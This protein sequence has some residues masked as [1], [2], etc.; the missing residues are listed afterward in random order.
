MVFCFAL[1]APALAGDEADRL[2]QE[3][4]QAVAST[5][6]MS[7]KAHKLRLELTEIYDFDGRVKKG[8]PHHKKIIEFAL[9]K[10]SADHPKVADRR[11]RY[12][13]ALRM[14]GYM[15]EAEEQLEQSYQNCLQQLG[16][17][18]KKTLQVKKELGLT[19]IRTGK[20]D[21]GIR[22]LEEVLEARKRDLGESAVTAAAM[23]QLAQGYLTYGRYADAEALVV[24]AQDIL[25]HTAKKA[26]LPY[27]YNLFLRG[28]IELSTHRYK[29][30][31]RSLQEGYALAAQILDPAHPRMSGFLVQIGRSLTY[32]GR[33]SEAEKLLLQALENR[34]RDLGEQSMRTIVIMGHLAR[35]Y[36]ETGRDKEAEALLT[37]ANVHVEG[38]GLTGSSFIKALNRLLLAELYVD[39]GRYHEAA[40]HLEIILAA[41][42]DRD[43]QIRARAEWY[44]GKVHM[45]ARQYDQALQ[46][47]RKA[48][49]VFTRFSGEDNAL[50]ARALADL[51]R[52]Y[53]QQ[54]DLGNAVDAYRRAMASMVAFLKS[55][56]AASP[57]AQRQQEEYATA[58]L[59]DYLDLM[60]KLQQG[61]RPADVDPLAEGFTV[62]ENARSRSLQ[63]AL[64]KMSARA[65]TRDKALAELVRQEQNLRL[66]QGV[67][68]EQLLEAMGEPPSQD[69]RRLIETLADTRKGLDADLEDLNR[70]ILEK[71]PGYGRLINPAT[72]G[73]QDARA[74]LKPGEV[75]LSYFVQKERTL[76]WAIDSAGARLHILSMGEAELV[77]KIRRL[78]L[79]MDVTITDL[80]R[81]P[82]Y[83]VALAHHLYEKLLA[84]A[85]PKEARHLIVVPHGA[86]TNLPFGALVTRKIAA[87]QRAPGALPFSE[88]REVPWLARD[89]AISIMPSATA[90]VTMRRFI[91]GGRAELAFV[92]FGDPQFGGGTRGTRRGD[93]QVTEVSQLPQLPETAE[94]LQRIQRTFGNGANTRLF[95]GAAATEENV[96][97]TDLSK[98]RVVTFATHGLLAGELRGLAQ[99]A[100]ALTP[101][102]VVSE[103]NNGLL[104]MEEVLE[105]NM[106]ADWVVLS[107]CNTAGSDGSLHGENLSGLAT[108]FF[109][110]GS[111]AMLV[112]LWP[113]VSSATA[114]LMA[115]VF[116][117]KEQSPELTRAAALAAARRHLIKGPGLVRDGKVVLSYAHPVFWSA[118][119][120]VGEGG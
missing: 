76:L 92:G 7:R 5:G 104:E 78:R 42:G 93:G 82:A 28:T 25:E 112:S 117:V 36:R 58:T 3:L 8:L 11:F 99:P 14:A 49:E 29:A 71:F 63:K 80:A 79:S 74:V 13:K 89:H 72:S 90:L 48:V 44:Q 52:A 50:T 19:Y 98:Y 113:V 21:E 57:A 110:A 33:Y 23:M 70:N 59:L 73:I 34:K 88:Y 105:L 68:E 103:E 12:G 120:L 114:E 54:G 116:A 62:A 2:E 97:H 20:L 43:V 106:N 111:R 30:A 15:G 108:A 102:P 86:L 46:H 65:A 100:L 69:N 10:L 118:F 96:K 26:S 109:Y 37:E 51:A 85:L 27:T 31:E 61:D 83:N 60:V 32:Q 39:T 47:L 107:A 9:S 55:A 38:L 35:L 64:L 6:E 17:E 67:L 22:Y 115:T 91:K 18:H 95:L 53:V 45:A 119:I 4:Q 24:R 40:P 16:P 87:P 56:E 66:R 101:P 94:E 81:V 1:S 75:L 41:M 84:P 77:K